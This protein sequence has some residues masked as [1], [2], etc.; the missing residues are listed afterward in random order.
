MPLLPAARMHTSR[1]PSS[2]PPHPL[3]PRLSP[4]PSPRAPLP[5]AP[6]LTTP[7]ATPL[8]AAHQILSTFGDLALVLGDSFEKY[9]DTVKRMLGQAMHLSV[10]QAASAG[11]DDFLD[12]NNELRIGILEAYS[13]LFQGLGPGTSC[14]RCADAALQ[15]EPARCASRGSGDERRIGVCLTAPCRCWCVRAW[16]AWCRCAGKADVLLK[17][18]VPLIIEFANSIGRDTQPDDTVVRNCV[19]L[20]GD[21]CTVV[22][23]V[24]RRRRGAPRCAALR[25]WPRMH[26]CCLAR[27]ACARL[28]CWR[29]APAAAAAAAP[30]S[31]MQVGPVLQQSSSNDWE[32]LLTYCQD[33]GHL[34]GDTEWA[35]NAVTASVNSASSTG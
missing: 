2:R 28:T 31:R 17:S 29:A 14:R 13:G 19:N 16:I 8:A 33:S 32:K 30:S 5:P 1:P 15:W 18:E 23:Q 12:Y 20:L 10:L 35:I 25:S 6:S 26:V 27:C 9:L 22:T 11:D 7:L 3:S 24:R 34:L 21:I 4:H